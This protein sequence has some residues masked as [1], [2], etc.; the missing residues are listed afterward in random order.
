MKTK[1]FIQTITIIVLLVGAV[2]LGSKI[3]NI[4]PPAPPDEHGD[5]GG[6]HEGHADAEPAKGPTG[7]RLFGEKDFQTEVTIY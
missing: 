1:T 5:G 4:Q 2:F 3:L 7:G 6:G